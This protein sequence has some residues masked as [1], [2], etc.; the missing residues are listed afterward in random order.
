MYVSAIVDE[1]LVPVWRSGASGLAVSLCAS[2]LS[3]D[4]QHECKA[5]STAFV[6]DDLFHYKRLLKKRV[7]ESWDRYATQGVVPLTVR[8][9][10]DAVLDLI[11][12]L[13]QYAF[14][15]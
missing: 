5:L 2:T 6:I 8:A 10:S 3:S 1:E 9:C 11:P 4:D 7:Q 12:D 13:M 15:L 14:R